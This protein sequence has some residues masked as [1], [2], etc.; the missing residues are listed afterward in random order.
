[1]WV[2]WVVG[3]GDSSEDFFISNSVVKG[4]T[5]IIMSPLPP[6]VRGDILVS[7]QISLV[8][9]FVLALASA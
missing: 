1:M 2:G 3:I 5:W 4:V 7:V 6:K 9:A 8:S